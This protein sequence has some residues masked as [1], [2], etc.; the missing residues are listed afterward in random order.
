MKRRI[1]KERQF[2]LRREFFIAGWNGRMKDI[3]RILQRHPDAPLWADDSN[4]G[5]TALQGAAAQCNT[6]VIKFLIEKGADINARDARGRTA[7]MHGA[8]NGGKTHVQALLDAGAD[9]SAVDNDGHDAI[10]H[11]TDSL[12]QPQNADLIRA[13]ARMLELKKAMEDE[14]RRQADIEGAATQMR[15]GAH[16]PVTIGKPLKLKI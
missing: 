8:G 2:A 11:T 15:D 10:W 5:M 12:P 16:R 1:R 9:I 4:D 13:H 14:A 3:T 6:D 7:L